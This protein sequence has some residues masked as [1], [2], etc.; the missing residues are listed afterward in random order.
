MGDYAH[1]PVTDDPIVV[2]FSGCKYL[3]DLYERIQK[4]F[5]ISS[6]LRKKLGCSLGLH[7]WIL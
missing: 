7:R 2:D 3:D 4:K 5:W 1:V 6:L